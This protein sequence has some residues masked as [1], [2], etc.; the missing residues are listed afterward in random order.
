[1]QNLSYSNHHRGQDLWFLPLQVMKCLIVAETEERFGLLVEIL[2]PLLFT[3]EKA[4]MTWVEGG[5][6]ETV[7]VG[8]GK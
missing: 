5:C 7:G 1:M 3:V 6:L 8:R 4:T 2:I